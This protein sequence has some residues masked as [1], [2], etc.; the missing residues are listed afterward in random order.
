ME[1]PENFETMFVKNYDEIEQL[2][3]EVGRRWECV[4]DQ[5]DLEGTERRGATM[6]TAIHQ[7]ESD[8]LYLQGRK[9]AMHSKILGDLLVCLDS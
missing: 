7:L 1:L 2:D 4:R 8:P 9:P 6:Q 5:W 3:E